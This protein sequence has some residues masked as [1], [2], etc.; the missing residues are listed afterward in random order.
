MLGEVRMNGN[1]IA[2]VAGAAILHG[3]VFAAEE[4]ASPRF[5]PAGF[6]PDQS[7]LMQRI[8]FPAISED[9]FIRV[10]CDGRV[11]RQGDLFRIF[12]WSEHPQAEPFLSS[13]YSRTDTVRMLPA[14]VD[15]EAE[16]VH[17]QY[18]VQFE[19][20]AG[21][22]SIK[23]FPHQFVGVAGSGENY[24]AP[25]RYNQNGSPD[26]TL[27]RCYDRYDIWYTMIIGADGGR[28][29][30]V[31]PVG[32]KHDRNCRSYYASE[33]K[34]GRYIPAHLNGVPVEAP[35]RELRTDADVWRYFREVEPFPAA[36]LPPPTIK[37]S[38]LP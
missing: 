27:T 8:A 10:Y 1:Y 20:K 25:Q 34:L 36:S 16:A 21:L 15:G 7:E 37:T 38:E 22:E 26:G 33:T 6:P 9:V 2:F 35:Y 31:A 13:L 5:Q 3:T 17:F 12:C 23:L 18:T 30:Q 14:M 29:Q 32:N 4:V 11:D 19:K 24:V 28:P